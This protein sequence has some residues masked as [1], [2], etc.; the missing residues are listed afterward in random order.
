M[1]TEKIRQAAG[2]F[3]TP[4]YIFDTDALKDRVKNIR[5]QLAGCADLCFAM[6]ANPFLTNALSDVVD[7]F[8]ICSPGEYHIYKKY[9]LPG[10]KIIYS[11]VYKDEETLS[12][13]LEDYTEEAT[14]T[15]ESEEHLRLI[16]QWTRNHGRTVNVLL[17]LTSGNQFGMDE[18]LVCKIIGERENYPDI[19]I[20]GIHYFSGTQKHKLSKIQKELE[21]LDQFC[22]FLKE[23]FAFEVQQLEYGPGAGI[24][25]FPSDKN[26]L[27][28][29]EMVT[30]IREII[31]NMQ[32]SGTIT[33]EMGRFLTAMC[34][35]YF[36]A[37]KDIKCNKGE[38]YVI[39]DGG[40]HQ[41]N[42]DGQLKGMYLPYLKQI[43]GDV[44]HKVE[45]AAGTIPYTICGAL[46]TVN[47]V[48]CR[49]APLHSPQKGDILIFER[50]GAYSVMEGMSLFLS[51]ELP[52]VILY[53]EED[54]FCVVRGH[55]KTEIYNS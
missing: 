30:G 23:D 51:R 22:L 48:I 10:N 38:N 26:V 31:K 32:F 50:T 1:N 33:L 4:F 55:I 39:T 53:G 37:V 5:E 47:D 40:I 52:Q 44:V 28:T 17:R 25:Y 36:T 45:P 46:C 11:G 9:Q 2:T 42:Y 16:D 14:Y 35:S 8:E 20:A 15:I 54:G 13:A 7:R 18:E 12:E 3:E 27:S 24:S 29:E 34:G 21:K 6:K 43:S 49:Q 19:H 41:L